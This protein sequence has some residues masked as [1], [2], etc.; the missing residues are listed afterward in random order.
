M[1]NS[2]TTAA[3]VIAMTVAACARASDVMVGSDGTY[4]ISAHAS[5]IRG[6]STKAD[7]IAYQRAQKFCALKD[8]KAHAIVVDTRDHGAFVWEGVNFRFK[9]GA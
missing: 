3:I 2:K 9:C 5:V 6:G 4:L 7:S 1:F 8:P